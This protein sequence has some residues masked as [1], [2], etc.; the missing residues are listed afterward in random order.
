MIWT[1]DSEDALGN[2][3]SDKKVNSSRGQIYASG[4]EKP[5]LESFPGFLNPSRNF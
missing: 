4:S 2:A 1:R 5:G 3:R